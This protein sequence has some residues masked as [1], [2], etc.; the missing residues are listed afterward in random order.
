MDGFEYAAGILTV[1][2]CGR[3][4]V[5]F[6]M[7]FN[8]REYHT[9]NRVALYADGRILLMSHKDTSPYKENTGFA[10]GIF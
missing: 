4:F 10:G 3:Y 1:P 5:Y 2:V 6:Q 9:S 8:S 7:F